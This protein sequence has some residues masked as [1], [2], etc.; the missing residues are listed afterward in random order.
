VLGA[1]FVYPMWQLGLISVLDFRQ[2]QVSGGQPARVVGLENYR[3][4]LADSQFWSV[5]SATVVFAA[6]CVVATLAVGAALAVLL[7]KAPRP[8]RPCRCWSS[9]SWYAAVW[10]P[11]SAGP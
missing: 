9:S 5:L 8:S 4:L 1:L 6:A 3:Q 11:A 7:T 2:A 10:W